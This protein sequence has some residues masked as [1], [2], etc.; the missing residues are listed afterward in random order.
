MKDRELMERAVKALKFFAQTV[1]GGAPTLTSLIDDLEIRIEEIK[2]DEVYYTLPK[3]TRDKLKM[4]AKGN[5]NVWKPELDSKYQKAKELRATGMILRDVCAV[6]G[7]TLDQWYRRQR[8]E[9]IGTDRP[10]RFE[11]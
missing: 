5:R 9:K 3:E 4:A 6:S 7:L 11:R 2:E 8:I 1:G 10:G